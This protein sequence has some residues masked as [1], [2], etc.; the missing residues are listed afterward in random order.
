VINE[1]IS[2]PP[3][4]LVRCIDPQRL[5]FGGYLDRAAVPLRPGRGHLQDMV[6]H[7]GHNISRVPVIDRRP[8]IGHEDIMP[9]RTDTHDG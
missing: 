8:R 1:V 9:R 5:A 2:H 6:H 3:Y 7:A 4:C